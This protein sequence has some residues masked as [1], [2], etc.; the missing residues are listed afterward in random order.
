MKLKCGPYPNH[1]RLVNDIDNMSA[2]TTT[3]I[4]RESK[5]VFLEPQLVI[6]LRHVSISGK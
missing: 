6:W 3:K 1:K 5:Q 4:S 2:S